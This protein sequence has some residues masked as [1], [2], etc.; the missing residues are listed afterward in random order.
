MGPFRG[1]EEFAHGAC[2]LLAARRPLAHAYQFPY[3]H[4]TLVSSPLFRHAK[5]CLCGAMWWFYNGLPRS[6]RRSW[7]WA[8]SGS[9][10]ATCCT[11]PRAEHGLGLG[12]TFLRNT[13]GFPIAESVVSYAPSDTFARA[14]WVG[15]LNTIKV[16]VVGIVLAT[17]LS[18][19]RGVGP[20]LG[21]LAG[22]QPRWPVHQYHPRRSL[23][24][25]LFIWY[26]AVFQRLPSVQQA[27]T[28][29]GPIYISQRGLYMAG[30]QPTATFGLWLIFVAAGLALGY[31]LHRALLRRQVR[32]GRSTYPL[33]VGA[34]AV[35]ATP[36][37]GWFLVGAV[38]M[39]I[40]A[41]GAG[42]SQ[43]KG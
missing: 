6:F 42:A 12:F 19:G 15:F 22:Q 10:S 21:Q 4:F 18:T 8:F 40:A 9:S 43:P 27:L 26:F 11:R 30:P 36:L 24:V 37:V 38:P 31:L 34:L 17:A 23:L 7:C 25:Q 32:T 39:H 41:P 5:A 14:L 33:L 1:C 16:S 13:A 29:P 2:E 28:L 35:L 3:G 20:A